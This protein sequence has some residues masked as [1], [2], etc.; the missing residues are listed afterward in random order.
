MPSLI[1]FNPRPQRLQAINL[2]LVATV[3]HWV[4][5]TVGIVGCLQG[6]GRQFRDML[7]LLAVPALRTAVDRCYR[8]ELVS[9]LGVEWQRV[10]DYAEAGG[11][12]PWKAVLVFIVFPAVLINLSTSLWTHRSLAAGDSWPVIPS[13]SSLVTDGDLEISEKMPLASRFD[14]MNNTGLPYFVARSGGNIYSAYPAGMLV[15]A[16]PV[17]LAARLCGADLDKIQVRDRL[18]RFTAAW[19][20]GACIGLFFLIAARIQDA[21]TAA[22]VAFLLASGSVM[23]STVGH[24]LWQHGGVIFWSLLFLL[25]EFQAAAKNAGGRSVLQGVCLGMTLTC[26]PS[27]VIIIVVGTAWIALRSRQRGLLVMLGAALGFAPWAILYLSLYG[28][29]LGPTQSQMGASNWGLSGESLLGVLACPSCGLFVY[30][31][32]LIVGLVSC[33]VYLVLLARRASEGQR[34]P[35]LARR[36]NKT[37]PAWGWYC[38][39]LIALQVLLVANWKCWWGGDCWGSRL[40]AEV[41]P[42][43]A[44]LCLR[45]IHFLLD[46]RWGTGFLIV[47]GF[48]SIYIHMCVFHSESIF[49]TRVQN[50]TKWTDAPFVP[51]AS[52][53][54]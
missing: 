8:T 2:S 4:L 35:S 1:L 5:S 51:D 25:L 47:L 22:A 29:L 34:C 45:P 30:Q 18:E 16:T 17:C 48:L 39:A 50:P 6:G 37:P 31:P 20:G 32:W 40:L 27:A 23:T 12:I 36:A 24:A 11:A 26:R 15:F 46:R 44:L 14:V 3:L 43:C 33:F 9:R 42:L 19:V 54:Y 38:T 10:K 21:K 7:L 53:I 41:V 13:A 49:P 28:T 52:H